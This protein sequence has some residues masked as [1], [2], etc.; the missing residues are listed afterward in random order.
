MTVVQTESHQGAAGNARLTG[1]AGAALFVLLAFVG[2][3]IF[4]VNSHLGWHFFLGMLVVPLVVLKSASTL[5]RFARYYS[6]DPDYVRKGA[7]RPLLRLAGPFVVVLTLAVLGTGIALGV[8]GP[9]S[10]GL[11]QAHKASFIL[12]FAVMAVHVLGHLLETPGLAFADWTRRERGMVPGATARLALV[13]GA[14]VAGLLLAYVTR[15]WTHAW[16]ETKRFG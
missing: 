10:G 13:I 2:V 9:G 11:A 12:W 4:R 3:T 7:P 6:G 15:D 14:V 5:Y 16:P 8:R 1:M